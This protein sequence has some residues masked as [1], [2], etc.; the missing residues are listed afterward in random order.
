MA[1][2][3]DGANRLDIRV[4]HPSRLIVGVTDIV[5]GYGLLSA[6]LAL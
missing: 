6:N 3:D 1:L 4:E 5:A 2:A